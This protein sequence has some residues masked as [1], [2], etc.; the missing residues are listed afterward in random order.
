VSSWLKIAC[1]YQKSPFKAGFS[2]SCAGS[3]RSGTFD[4]ASIIS[5]RASVCQYVDFLINVLYAVNIVYNCRKAAKGLKMARLYTIT[6]NDYSNE[7]TSTTIG[8]DPAAIAGDITAWENAV[9]AVAA[10]TYAS[11]Q[12]ST[13]NRYSNAPAVSVNAQREEKLLVS[14]EDNVT[15]A[16]YTFSIGTFLK[17]AVTFKP[18]TDDVDISTGGGLTLKNAFEAIAVSPAGNPCSVLGMKYVGRSS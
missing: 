1:R 13:I 18:N 12:D 6:F 10:G 5:G 4:H 16:R 11:D 3:F 17:S 14:Y 15:F 2:A 8:I 7:K 9:D